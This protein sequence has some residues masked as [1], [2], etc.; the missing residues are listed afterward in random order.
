MHDSST[1]SVIAAPTVTFK[2]LTSEVAQYSFFRRGLT[3]VWTT[4]FFCSWIC[5]TVSC[6]ESSLWK[7]V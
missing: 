2:H 3:H 5:P 1:A 4:R 6:R 7:S